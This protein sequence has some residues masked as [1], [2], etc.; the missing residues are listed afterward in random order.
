M[1]AVYGSMLRSAKGRYVAN[2]GEEGWGFRG[3]GHPKKN[4]GFREGQA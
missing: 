1:F 3:E 2:W 4:G